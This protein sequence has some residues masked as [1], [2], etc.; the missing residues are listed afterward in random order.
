VWWPTQ[1][2]PGR[3]WFGALAAPASLIA[4]AISRDPAVSILIAGLLSLA[5]SMQL[6]VIQQMIQ[7]STPG[8]FRGRVMS[9]HGITFNGTMPFAALITSVLAVAAGLPAVMVLSAAAY[10][11]CAI[12]LLRFGAG[13]IGAVVRA[14]KAEFEII[15]AG[16]PRAASHGPGR[17]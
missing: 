12:F 7:E 11:A 8:D 13:G 5:F 10:L 17:S 4:M 6:G 3:I 15:A 14:S 9:L 2:R 1:A 16:P